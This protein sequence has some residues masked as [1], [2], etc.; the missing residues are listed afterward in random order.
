MPVFYPDKLIKIFTIFVVG[1]ISFWLYFFLKLPDF[2][3]QPGVR[4]ALFLIGFYSY[5]FVAGSLFSYYIAQA[6]KKFATS[7]EKNKKKYFRVS[8]FILGL[9]YIIIDTVLEKSVWIFLRDLVMVALILI[10]MPKIS[11]W[12]DDKIT[13]WGKRQNSSK[14]K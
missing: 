5:F 7:F 12:V 8:V 10:A 14:L 6:K 3:F 4:F 9:S 11:N 1:T 13:K 2:T